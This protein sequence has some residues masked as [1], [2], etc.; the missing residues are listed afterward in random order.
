M[1]CAKCE[2]NPCTCAK[3]TALSAWVIQ[4]CS[5]KGCNVAIR[6]RAG[7]QEAVPVCRWCLN[8]TAYINDYTNYAAMSA[9]RA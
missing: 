3:T 8:N 9:N 5:T 7:Q 1:Y 6:M 2:D 4:H